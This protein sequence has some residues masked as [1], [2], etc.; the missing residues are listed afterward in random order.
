MKMILSVIIVFQAIASLSF[1]FDEE[2]PCANGWPAFAICSSDPDV[3]QT[4]AC[5]DPNKKDG[6]LVLHTLD[7]KTK[8]IT[9][10]VGTVIKSESGG[11]IISTPKSATKYFV[12]MDLPYGKGFALGF[13]TDTPSYDV[14]EGERIVCG[15]INRP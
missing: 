6:S 3:T 15:I 7:V 13:R 1:A 8:K 5:L 9:E 11:I 12:M 14:D 2:R 10:E 4:R